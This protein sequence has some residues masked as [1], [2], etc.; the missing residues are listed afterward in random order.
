MAADIQVSQLDPE[1]QSIP[2]PAAPVVQW[3]LAT[4]IA[5]RMCFIYF[6]LFTFSNQILGGLL[7]FPKLN[8]PDFG[9]LWPLRQITF[10]AAKH[11]F[12]VTYQLVYTGSGSGDKTYDWVMT[13]CLLVIAAMGTLIWSLADRR[14]ENYVSLY[15]W[16]R[17]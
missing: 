15:K 8:L 17:V 4:R 16:F 10:W 3:S 7:N 9:A 2:A 14:R 6:I 12:H 11:I 13:F 5:F 1:S